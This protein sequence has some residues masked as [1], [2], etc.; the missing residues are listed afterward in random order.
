M[1]LIYHRDRYRSGGSELYR[2]YEFFESASKQRL[3]WLDDGREV[4]RARM[5]L[6]PHYL[7]RLFS[8]KCRQ[9]K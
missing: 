4:H 8:K 3:R 6:L 9:V 7:L 5:I 1:S 2:L